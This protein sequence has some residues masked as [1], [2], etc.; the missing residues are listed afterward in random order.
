[1]QDVCRILDI[2]IATGHGVSPTVLNGLDADEKRLLTRQDLASEDFLR[3]VG[4]KSVARL[5]VIS[6]SGLYKLIMRSNKPEAYTV[7]A[8]YRNSQFRFVGF[9]LPGPG[10]LSPIPKTLA[11]PL[12]P[13]RAKWPQPLPRKPTHPTGGGGGSQ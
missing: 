13:P 7:G 4:H 11:L 8:A 5:R 6:E 9:T 10:K 3:L 2:G 12:T 1:M